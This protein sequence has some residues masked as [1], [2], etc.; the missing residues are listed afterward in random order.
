[1]DKEDVGCAYI[2]GI[3]TPI[4]IYYKYIQWNGILPSHKK[5]LSFTTAY[6]VNLIQKWTFLQRR[7]KDA[8]KHMK[9]SQSLGKS[10]SKLKITPHTH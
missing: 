2:N 4:Y 10:K 1:M 3:Y 5:I 8:K 7:Y 6:K 9:D